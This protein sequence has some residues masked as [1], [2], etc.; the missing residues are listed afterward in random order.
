[1]ANSGVDPV[2]KMLEEVGDISI[3]QLDKNL[4]RT[5]GQANPADLTKIGLLMPVARRESPEYFSWSLM[6]E[7]S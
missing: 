7:K 6:H 1:M 4:L 5:P 2:Y 3:F